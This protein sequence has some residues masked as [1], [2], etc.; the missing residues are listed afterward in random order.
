MNRLPVLLLAIA[1]LFSSFGLGCATLYYAEPPNA[2][3]LRRYRDMGRG[4][5][6]RKTAYGPVEHLRGRRK[7][8]VMPVQ[9]S[10]EVRMEWFMRSGRMERELA[11]AITAA[12]AALRQELAAEF[13]VL[14]D[15]S[16]I[17]PETV[18]VSAMVTD[19]AAVRMPGAPDVGWRKVF[20]PRP[21]A[22]IEIAVRVPR[23]EEVL[24]RIKDWR[25]GRKRTATPVEDRTDFGSLRTIFHFWGER[26]TD[27]L[28]DEARKEPTEREERRGFLHIP[29][30]D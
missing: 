1:A 28:A 23:Q 14:Q 12:G 16:F 29:D 22:A 30:Y 6:F 3:H 10:L 8:V 24:I 2:G 4:T 26:L 21:R 7:V 11:Q 15:P 9:T 27:M 17:D 18:I 20:P 5:H 25:S 19:L 13:V